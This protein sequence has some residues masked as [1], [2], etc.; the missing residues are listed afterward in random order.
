MDRLMYSVEE[1]AQATGLGRTKIYELMASGEITAVKVGNRRL[2]PAEA[3]RE[4]VRNLVVTATQGA[5]ND[6]A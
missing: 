4:F 6:A 5:T 1:A 2:I 3:L